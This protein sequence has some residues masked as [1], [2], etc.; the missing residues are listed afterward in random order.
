MYLPNRRV[1][2]IVKTHK[3]Y[4]LN[5]T[6]LTSF[7]CENLLIFDILCGKIKAITNLRFI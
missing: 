6:K 2:I 3:I 7:I 5:I 1:Y 4:K